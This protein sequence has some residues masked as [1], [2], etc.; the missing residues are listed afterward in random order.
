MS[1]WM[2]KSFDYH[3]A[4]EDEYRAL[5]HFTVAMRKERHPHDPPLGESEFVARIKSI[6]D[7]IDMRS[8]VAITEDGDI[9]GEANS[10]VMPG[11]DNPHLMQASIEVHPQ[12]R[13]RGIGRRL[14][15]FVADEALRRD[16]TLTLLESFSTAPAG[17]AFAQRIGASL[18]ASS[19]TNQLVLGEVDRSLV[20]RWLDAAWLLTALGLLGC[21]TI[22]ARSR[23]RPPGTVASWTPT[24][25]LPSRTPAN[26][27]STIVTIAVFSA[28]LIGPGWGL[29][30]LAAGLMV[31]LRDRALEWFATFLIGTVVVW[32][33]V[34]NR[35]QQPPP[36]LAWPMEFSVVHPLALFAVVVLV[37]ATLFA[38]DASPIGSER[39]GTDH[40][41]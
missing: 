21:L 33:A 37:G 30:G 15:G 32:I 23:R 38:S 1:D 31:Y 39:S 41:A 12:Q 8:V 35:L 6:P 27:R 20:Q 16:R 2:I 29:I 40:D 19:R 11:A 36:D 10:F 5:Y 26:P 13:R 25:P 17:E 24:R 18:G 4:S 22:V 28:V 3:N 14:L 34:T 7:A 9:L